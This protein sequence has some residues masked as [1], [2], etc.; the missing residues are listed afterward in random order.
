[1]A[2]P[3][4]GAFLRF[5]RA[6]THLAECSHLLK[7][8]EN[9]CV[10]KIGCDSEGEYRFIGGWPDIPPLLSVLAGEVVYNLR[11]ALDY[12]IYELAIKDSGSVHDG[13][14]F[15]IEDLKS[16][17]INKN[18]GFDARRKDCLKWLSPTHTDRI[19]DVQPY[20]GVEWTKTLQDISN[21]DKHRHLTVL[22]HDGRMLNYTQ[23]WHDEG[24]FESTRAWYQTP[25]GPVFDRFDINVDGKQ[26][27]AIDLS[28]GGQTPLVPTLR[29]V[30]AGVVG[31]LEAFKPEF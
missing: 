16:D 15:P 4:D 14:Q 10:D 19:E 13:T 6:D 7:S 1:M 5:N 12:L 31:L 21:P 30:E 18:R 27:I 2:H 20:N 25:K 26:T 28:K 29:C 8:W 22:T 3:L 11:A 9:A 17:P 24:R 23:Q